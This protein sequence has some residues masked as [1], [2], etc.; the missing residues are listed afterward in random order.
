MN[1]ISLPK[2]IYK[3]LNAH[4]IPLAHF[5][6]LASML[7]NSFHCIF[8]IRYNISWDTAGHDSY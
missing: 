1:L 5:E 8:D 4:L 2:N 3:I 7:C 6:Y